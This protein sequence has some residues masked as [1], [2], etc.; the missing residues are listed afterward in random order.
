MAFVVR[1][2]GANENRS[3]FLLLLASLFFRSFF[4]DFIHLWDGRWFYSQIVASSHNPFDLNGLIFYGHNSLLYLMLMSIPQILFPENHVLFNAWN[5]IW[6]CVG[7]AAFHGL[8]KHYFYLRTTQAERLLVT[9]CLAFHP[10]FLGVTTNF[11]LD[12]GVTIFLLIFW[13]ALLKRSFRTA[14]VAGLFL[15]FSKESGILLYPFPLA[16]LFLDA[17]LSH[18]EKDRVKLIVFIHGAIFLAY[19]LIRLKSAGS[20]FHTHHAAS[21]LDTYKYLLTTIAFDFPALRL[22]THLL[23][24]SFNWLLLVIACGFGITGLIRSRRGQPRLFD[25]RMPPITRPE[26]RVQ[27]FLA[28]FLV[29]GIFLL[30]RAVRWPNVRYILPLLPV[31]LLAVTGILSMSAGT[32]VRLTVWS[33]FIPIFLTSTFRTLDPVSKKVLGTQKFGSNTVLMGYSLDEYNYN[34]EYYMTH[35]LQTLVFKEIRPTH[36]TVLITSESLWWIPTAP[37]VAGGSADE[38]HDVVMP[39]RGS[40]NPNYTVP[41]RFLQWPEKPKDFYFLCYPY[42]NNS[43]EIGRLKYHFPNYDEHTVV[44]DGYSMSYIHFRNS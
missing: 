3:L 19:V 12:I 28:A 13:L 35:R 39:R 44:E 22:I 18:R 42:L 9:A 41:W 26:F 21:S 25:F 10:L 8:V 31:V 32:R 11:N 7:V 29:I 43:P 33:I 38:N 36:G 20:V 16:A 14:F 2:I 4:W 24:G 1:N 17:S 27:L 34:L 6:V 30:T 15:L 5:S 37:N 23:I 40:L